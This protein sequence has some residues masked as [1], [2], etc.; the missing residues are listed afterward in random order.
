MVRSAK[1]TQLTRI[2]GKNIGHK[3]AS[4]M[5]KKID[6]FFNVRKI[7]KKT[8]IA[9]NIYVMIA[10]K[11]KVPMVEN[12]LAKIFDFVKICFYSKI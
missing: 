7:N 5:V 8:T 11:Y 3:P 2:A 1:T 6:F 10:T 4:A 9:N 12:T